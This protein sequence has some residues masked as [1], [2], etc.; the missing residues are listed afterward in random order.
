M[1]IGDSVHNRRDGYRIEQE[2]WFC[3]ARRRRRITLLLDMIFEKEDCG[4]SKD[5]KCP[6]ATEALN[7]VAL[8]LLTLTKVHFIYLFYLFYLLILFIYFIYLFI[9]FIYLFYLFIILFIYLLFYLFI[10]LFI[11][12]IYLFYLFIY[13]IN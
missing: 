6:I 10:Y 2:E 8:S 11:Y 1:C 4:D 7:N 9:Y 3:D 12:L 5:T 13:L